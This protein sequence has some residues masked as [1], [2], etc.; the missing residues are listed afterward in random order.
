[1]VLPERNAEKAFEKI[2]VMSSTTQGQ[3]L[4]SSP[5]SSRALVFCSGGGVTRSFVVANVIRI[6]I[7]DTTAKI[8]MVSWKPRVSLPAPRCL[9]SG[10]TNS[11]IRKAALN[12]PTN[13][14]VEAMVRVRGE[15]LMTPSIAEYGT[16]MTV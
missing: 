8:A 15:G 2:D 1:M 12:A 5:S 4:K 7:T 11:E 10:R 6:R 14:H 16:L 3:F 13:R 9:T